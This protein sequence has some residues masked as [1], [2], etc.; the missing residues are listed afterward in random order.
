EAIVRSTIETHF[1]DDPTVAA[2]LLGLHFHDCFVKGWDGSILIKGKSDEINAFPNLGLRG[3]AKTQLEAL[4]PGVVP[5]ADILAL[6]ARESVDLYHIITFKTL[7]GMIICHELQSDGPNW[8]VH[9]KGLNDRDLVTLTSN[10]KPSTC[11]DE[12]RIPTLQSIAIVGDITPS[13]GVPKAKKNRMEKE[14]LENMCKLLGGRT[15]GHIA[16]EEMHALWIEYE[17]NSTPE[18]KVVKP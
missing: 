4:F 12:G 18:A 7:S 5:F 2:A 15:G 8:A 16:S 9:D 10:M 14:A 6:A 11:S 17:E 13:N 3:Y 1:K